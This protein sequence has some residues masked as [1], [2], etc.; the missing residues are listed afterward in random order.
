MGGTRISRPNP[1]LWGQT[2]EPG[3]AG[4]AF[5][6]AVSPPLHFWPLGVHWAS[7]RLSHA[8]ARPACEPGGYR[9]PGLL[10]QR[11]AKPRRP[12]LR[13]LWSGEGAEELSKGH[14]KPKHLPT[15]ST[16][17]A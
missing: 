11:R 10:C 12:K 16:L 5:W 15:T 1:G 8:G 6:E 13:S 4:Q 17:L 7:P 14:V 9:S 2:A 3:E